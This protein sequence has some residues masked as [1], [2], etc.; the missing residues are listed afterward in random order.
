MRLPSGNEDHGFALLATIGLVVPVGIV[1]RKYA[2]KIGKR[3]PWW[4]SKLDKR[5]AVMNYLFKKAGDNSIN[6]TTER[7]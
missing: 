7:N 2:H 6:P 4:L 5:A 3:K 1:Y